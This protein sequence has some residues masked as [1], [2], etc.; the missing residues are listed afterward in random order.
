MTIVDANSFVV[1]DNS[2]VYQFDFTGKFIRHIGA[3]G[4]S[5]YEYLQPMCV[6]TFNGSIY[7]WSSWI[8]K[9]IEYNNVGI[10]I[11]EYAYSSGVTDFIPTEDKIIIYTSGKRDQNTVDILNKLTGEIEASIIPTTALHRLLSK[12]WSRQPLCVDEKVLYVMRKDALTIYAYDLTEDHREM[13]PITLES[14]TF[15]INDENIK[16]DRFW[17]YYCSNSEVVLL[18]KAKNGFRILAREGMLSYEDGSKLNK[19]KAFY[20]L[21]TIRDNKLRKREHYTA[22]TLPDLSLVS[23]YDSHIYALDHSIENDDDVYKL[24]RVDL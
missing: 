8:P 6:R 3:P 1:C 24:V 17:E 9:I 13:S 21:Y 18:I 14:D 10:P 22:E 4:R 11:A 16:S 2:K 23:F 5:T 20:T 7:V 12:F 15:L 19:E